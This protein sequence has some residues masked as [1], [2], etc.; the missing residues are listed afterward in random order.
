MK[1]TVLLFLTTLSSRWAA[2][3]AARCLHGINSNVENTDV[4]EVKNYEVSAREIFP[5]CWAVILTFFMKSGY[6]T[7]AKSLS[8]FR[9]FD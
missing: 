4:I 9:P 8:E 7:V 1:F 5:N 6:V 3:E 2:K